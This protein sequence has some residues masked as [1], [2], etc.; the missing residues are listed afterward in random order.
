MVTAETEL[1]PVGTRE[2]ATMRARLRRRRVAEGRK[3]PEDYV[4]PAAAQYTLRVLHNEYG[5]TYE[6]LGEIFGLERS[7]LQSICSGQ[8][9][10]VTKKTHDRIASVDI[11]KVVL[12]EKPSNG[13]I[14]A[15]PYRLRLRQLGAA[16]WTRDALSDVIGVDISQYNVWRDDAKYISPKTAVTL[17]ELFRRIGDKKGPSDTIALRYLRRG[18]GPPAAYDDDG[19]LVPEALPEIPPA[20]R[21]RKAG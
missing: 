11:V 1:P 5:F 13:R 4:S 9:K 6:R 19:T 14:P 2:R 10:W 20:R 3:G 18:F 15:A 7:F 16:G 17:D 12:K 21:S 8:R